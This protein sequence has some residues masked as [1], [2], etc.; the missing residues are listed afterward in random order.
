MK[1]IIT[2]LVLSLLIFS[3]SGIAFAD[4]NKKHGHKQE[5]SSHSRPGSSSQNGFHSDKNHNV[6]NRRKDKHNSLSRPGS[7]Q[8]VKHRRPHYDNHNKKHGISSSYKKQLNK[9]VKYA[10][11]GGRNVS[12]WQ[13]DSDTFIIRYLLG[14]QYYTQRLYP[15]SKRYG[16]RKLVNV[17]WTPLSS[18]S[19]IPPISININL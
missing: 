19:I 7:M 10:T 18:W 6:G 11:R 17:N 14:N 3:G 15:G 5:Q 13:I 12:I 9:M 1:R 16:A 4:N 2:L 8:D